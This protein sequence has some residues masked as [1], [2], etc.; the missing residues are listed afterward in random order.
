MTEQKQR[1]LVLLS[2]GMDSATSAFIAAQDFEVCTI[3]FRYGQRTELK[4]LICFERISNCLNAEERK[5]VDLPFYRELQGSALT[6][7]SIEIPKTDG[8]GIPIT[9]IPFRNGVLLSIA[10]AYA[11]TKGIHHIFIG[12]V[13]EDSSGYP[14]CREVF[15]Q[16]LEKSINLGM[17]PESRITI[18]YPV[19][20]LKKSEILELGYSLGVPYE[21]TWSCYKLLDKP[22]L[23]CASCRLRAKAFGQIGKVDP[24]IIK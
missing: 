19:I 22:C 17:K 15:L 7:F 24:L 11:E 18:H 1:A 23:E 6:D 12:A 2:G 4:E 20:H 10:A 3:F 9:Y 5:V 8:L 14:D 13:Q 21:H 16:S